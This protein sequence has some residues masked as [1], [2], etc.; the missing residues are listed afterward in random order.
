MQQYWGTWM[1]AASVRLGRASGSGNGSYRQWER[2]NPVDVSHGGGAVC[3]ADDDSQRSSRRE[4]WH[5]TRRRRSSRLEPA[6]PGCQNRPTGARTGPQL[7]LGAAGDKG[8]ASLS[9][10]SLAKRVRS[11]GHLAIWHVL[12]P[13]FPPP[14]PPVPGRE[15]PYPLLLHNYGAAVVVSFIE[16]IQKA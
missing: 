13:T 1:L 3:G 15:D 5:Y 9:S 14:H 11:L 6:L 16:R 8:W 12:P 2:R 4:L 10:T 7:L